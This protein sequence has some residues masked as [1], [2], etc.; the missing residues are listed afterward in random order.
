VSIA[1][2]IDTICGIFAAGLAPKGSA[3]PFGLRRSAIGILQMS[4][5]GTP[6]KL[7]ELIGSALAG[8]GEMEMPSGVEGIGAAVKAFFI[9]RFEGILRDRGFAYDTV[10]AVLAVA[11][12]D[13]ADV[14]ARCESLTAAREQSPDTFEDLAV[15]FKRAANLAG[16]ASDAFDPALLG[17]HEK[18]LVEALDAASGRVGMLIEESAYG[19]L[20]ETYAALRGPIDEFFDN[21]MVMDE[22]PELRANRLA[23]LVRFVRTFMRF[24]DFSKLAG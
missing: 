8:Y 23:L 13:P 6:I 18:T 9:A 4:M 20:L 14:L 2:K 21:V 16:D 17:P 3:D 15:A 10:D 5:D 12:D 1:D 24:A 19:A 11:A 7:D 22:N